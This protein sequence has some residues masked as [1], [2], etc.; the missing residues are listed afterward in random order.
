MT[1][2]EV[3][4][5]AKE[6]G[7]SVYYYYVRARELWDNMGEII[8][9]ARK[10]F[11]PTEEDYEEMFAVLS[12]MQIQNMEEY[13]HVVNEIRKEKQPQTLIGRLLRLETFLQLSGRKKVTVPEFYNIEVAVKHNL[14]KD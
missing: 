6:Q 13:K 2:K 11:E 12:R 5:E 9:V 1:Y 8:R 10:E 4:K 7:K 14:F 3:A